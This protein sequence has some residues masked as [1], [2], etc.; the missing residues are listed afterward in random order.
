MTADK[1][2]VVYVGGIPSSMTEDVIKEHFSK[3]DNIVNVRIMKYRKTRGSKGY[4][5]V[6]VTDHLKIPL[7]LD[8]QQVIAGRTVD[9]QVAS[10]RGEKEKWKEEQTRKRL[11]VSNLPN[12][13]SNYELC[14]YFSSF[15]EV[16]NA[17]VIKDFAT[18]N[19]LNYGY[20]EFAKAGIIDTLIN[21][22]NLKLEG[23]NL[24]CMSYQG[25]NQDKKASL[26]Q[27]LT[28]KSSQKLNLS[29]L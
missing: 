5:F 22:V 14:V 8:E 16:R 11:F 4:A 10:R 27:Q 12:K 29:K 20:V 21:S 23:S 15:G 26:Q 18:K 3:Y 13:V 6:T 9:V 25:K 28:Q 24:I 2:R 7:I 19:S 17:Y 1:R